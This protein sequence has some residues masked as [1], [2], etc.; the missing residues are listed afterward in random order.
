MTNAQTLIG[1]ERQRQRIP[2]ESLKELEW[3]TNDELA[4]INVHGTSD[5]PEVRDKASGKV[6]VASGRDWRTYCGW[7]L[8]Y[9]VACGVEVYLDV[10]EAGALGGGKD[11]KSVRPPSGEHHLNDV[12]RR[13]T[14]A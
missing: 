6:L 14:R 4:W 1:A 13:R 5:R 9:R 11:W 10:P 12:R 3:L 8:D 7:E 2:D